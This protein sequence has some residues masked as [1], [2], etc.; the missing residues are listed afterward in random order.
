MCDFISESDLLKHAHENGVDILVDVGID[1]QSCRD[2]MKRAENHSEVFAV[3]GIHPHD[4][5]K[6]QETDLDFIADNYT[7]PRVIAIGEIGLD[8]YRDYSPRDIQKQ[9]FETQLRFAG[10]HK[11]PVVIHSRKAWDDTYSILQSVKRDLDIN[12]VF[13]C[14]GYSQEELKHV[15]D[16]GFF[17]SFPGA[18]T[19]EN[20]KKLTSA[21]R[22]IPMKWALIETDSPFITPAKYKSSR[23]NLPGYVVETAKAFAALRGMKPELLMPI[24]YKNTL[25]CFPKLKSALEKV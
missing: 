6:V 11:I 15:L 3:I 18:L 23:G 17:V 16:M 24:L 4:V 13:H 1:G 10:E 14:Y 21:A 8:Y 7:N 22:I 12:G 9:Y 20:A 5:K 2:V 19:Y 25:N